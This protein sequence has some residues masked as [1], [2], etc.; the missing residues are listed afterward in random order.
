[1]A[2]RLI[3]LRL[4]IDRRMVRSV[5]REMCQFGTCAAFVL[6]TVQPAGRSEPWLGNAPAGYTTKMRSSGTH[7][8]ESDLECSLP[9]ASSG[10]A[11]GVDY[12]D[13]Q[14]GPIRS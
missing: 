13:V 12:V 4:C 6:N 2:H 1:M 8:D 3:K 11:G 9:L 10:V 5:E 7:D 14:T